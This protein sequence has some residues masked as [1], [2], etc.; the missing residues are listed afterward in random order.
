MRSV[1]WNRL[2]FKN[3]QVDS[4]L[5]SHVESSYLNKDEC[6]FESSQNDSTAQSADTF[7][8]TA[9]ENLEL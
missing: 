6:K 8:R 2:P 7:S 5:I 3:L 4:L 1:S 9:T